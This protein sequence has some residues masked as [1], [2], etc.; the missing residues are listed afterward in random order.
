MTDDTQQEIDYQV[1]IRPGVFWYGCACG[2]SWPHEEKPGGRDCPECGGHIRGPM[3]LDKLE[4]LL[5]HGE[6]PPQTPRVCGFCGEWM[7]VGT[8]Q[9]VSIC[10]AC[11]NAGLHSQTTRHIVAEGH[12][13]IAPLVNSVRIA[14]D[15]HRS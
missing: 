10:K 13:E 2:E 15:K 3:P 12:H 1:S 14:R 8:G 11:W 6:Y 4:L 7:R 5:E 9:E